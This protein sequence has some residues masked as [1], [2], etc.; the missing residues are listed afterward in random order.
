MGY[1]SEFLIDEF[2]VFSAGQGHDLLL[3]VG[4]Q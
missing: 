3:A 1:L 2:V 4:A